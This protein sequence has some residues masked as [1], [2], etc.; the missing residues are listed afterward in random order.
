MLY[1]RKHIEVA[2]EELRPKYRRYS[3]KE[4]KVILDAASSSE[5]NHAE[6]LRELRKKRGFE[7]VYGGHLNYWMRNKVPKKMGRPIDSA[8]LAELLDHLIYT[9]LESAHEPEK[10]SVL[11][12]VAYSHATI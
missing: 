10:V 12:N 4:K 11:A 5:T 3:Q 9:S 7:R 6:L 8:F 1:V 2:L